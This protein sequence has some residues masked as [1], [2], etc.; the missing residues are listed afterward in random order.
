LVSFGAAA[1]TLA[2]SVGFP[3]A[4]VDLDKPHTDPTQNDAQ[5]QSKEQSFSSKRK[6]NCKGSQIQQ[7]AVNELR[8]QYLNNKMHRQT[9]LKANSLILSSLNNA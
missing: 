1:P 5:A 2:G 6:Q 7:V 3:R 4:L 8:H 9:K